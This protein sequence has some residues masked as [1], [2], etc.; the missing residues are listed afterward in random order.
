ML[1]VPD[2][3]YARSGGV[4]V[5]YQVVGDGPQDLVFLPFL[6]NLYSLWQLPVF[7]AG[8]LRLAASYRLILVNTRGMGLSDRPRGLTIEARMDDVRAVMDEV[9]SER[10]SLL[11]WAE[12]GN[13]CIVF[14]ATY[15][16]RVER[17]ILYTP[18]ARGTRS[19]DY[20]WGPSRE[21]ALADTADARER[22]GD[23]QYLE[24]FARRMNPQWAGDPSYLEWFVWNHRL[25]SSPE[26]YVEF[27]RMT[28][29]TDVSDVLPAVRVPTLVLS[30]ERTREPA[31]HLAALIS[32]ARAQVLPGEGASLHEN[33]AGLDAIESFMRDEV[34]AEIP[35][36]VLATVLFTDLVDSTQLAAEVGD[37]RWRLLL[38]RHYEFVRREL[39]RYRGVELDT[40]GDGVFA[41]FDGPARAIACA[42]AIVAAMPPL[43]LTIRAGI[44]TGECER[45]N[46]K[47]AGLAVNIGARISAVAETGEVLVSGTVRDL[48]AGSGFTFDDRGERELK[49]IPGAWRLYAVL[50]A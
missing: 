6:S 14:A 2:V 4:A 48:V 10:A 30:K 35:D 43:G 26:S 44:H 21:E 22:W 40:A 46:D 18:Y 29:E 24:D 19:D 36:T 1:D 32:G 50:D 23:R 27:R 38:E 7:A 34:L 12:T 5:A 39:A 41:S 13:T 11:G 8:T 49:G 3:R 33:D 45:V 15:P 37:R 47:L 16:E 17:L 28:L 9:G 20:P 25:S 31:A 42:Q